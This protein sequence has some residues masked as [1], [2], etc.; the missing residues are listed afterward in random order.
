MSPGG[1]FET[2]HAVGFRNPFSEKS[3]YFNFPSRL[4]DTFAGIQI[5]FLSVGL[6]ELVGWIGSIGGLICSGDVGLV[7][8]WTLWIR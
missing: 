5:D 7:G 6:V 8:D 4:A 1:H 2:R 3:F